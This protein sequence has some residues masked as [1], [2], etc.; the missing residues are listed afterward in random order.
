MDNSN[1]VGS[2]VPGDNHDYVSPNL[3]SQLTGIRLKIVHEMIN[4]RELR[5]ISADGKI[6]VAIDQRFSRCFCNVPREIDWANA[7]REQ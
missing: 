5:T 7:R 1:R 6:K 4:Q 3:F 2:F